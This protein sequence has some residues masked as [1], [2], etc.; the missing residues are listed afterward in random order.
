MTETEKQTDTPTYAQNYKVIDHC[1][2]EVRNSKQ[3]PYDRKLCNFT[4]W[5][6]SEVTLDDG[7]ETTTRIRLRGVHQSGRVLPE[8][9]I[10]ADELGN[11][12]WVA[13]HWGIHCILEVGQNVKDS[14]RYA[15]QTTA[16]NASRRTVY[17]VTGWKQIDG[18][19]QFL[20][21]GD[22]ATTVHLPGK[23]RG[24]R[25]EREC[26]A[27]DIQTAACMLQMMPAPEEITLPLLAFTFLTPLNHFLKLAGCEPKFVL[28]LIGK[29]GSRKSTLAALF[30][31]FFGRFT[32]AELPLSFRDTANSILH[33]AFT[34]KDV[35]TCIDDFHPAGKQ[36]EQKLTATAQSI[37]R[38]YGDRTGKGRLRADSTPMDSRPPQGNAILTAEFPPDIGESGTARYFALELRGE[39]VD[40]PTLT[41]FQNEADK[42]TLRNCMYGYLEWLKETFLC[43]DDMQKSFI[44]F[45][46]SRFLS[47]REEFQKSGILCH[48]RVP[49]TVSLLQLGMDMLLLF[50]K[51]NSAIDEESCAEIQDRFKGILCNLARKQADSIV[52][53]KPVCKFIR[54][55]YALLESGQVCVLSKNQFH[56]FVPSNCIGYEDDVFFYLHSEIAHR[57]VKKLCEEQGE[58]FS[59]SSKGLLKALAEEK[60]IETCAGQN[61]KAVRIGG[62]SKRVACLY[63]E[64]AKKIVDAAL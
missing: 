38:A 49:E 18:Q 44:A 5:I 11:F 23:M 25:M 48:G 42:G 6:V 17:A 13:R 35:L 47:G 51:E 9:E 50:L 7:M 58:S 34:L 61:T 21:P 14:I 20:M 43:S 27:L 16:Q 53:D 39:D 57:A 40:L 28:F 41:A 15:I 33:N 10:P 37:M 12:N 30:L 59:V 36:E 55:L 54:K 45:L 56:D 2:V 22:K 64:K 29:T 3:G 19:W 31:S 32:G 62:K 4:P 46:K 24:Y 26:S 1:L 52:Q 63:K 60:L 8:I